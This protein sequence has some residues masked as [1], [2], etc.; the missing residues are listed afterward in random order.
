MN[1]PASTFAYLSMRL[2]RIYSL[3]TELNL[4]FDKYLFVN[5]TE[6]TIVS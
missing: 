4:V 1:H 6:F 2:H 5:Y 3:F